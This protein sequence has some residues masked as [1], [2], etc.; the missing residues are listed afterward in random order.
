MEKP[1]QNVRALYLRDFNLLLEAFNLWLCI[2]CCK[3]KRCKVRLHGC[4]STELSREARF[5]DRFIK[6]MRVRVPLW[7]QIG[8]I[9]QWIGHLATNQ[10]MSVR[11]WLGSQK[12]GKP[13]GVLASLGKRLGRV[14]LT[15]TRALCLPLNFWHT[16]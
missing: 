9:V 7:I 8:S 4:R 16:F 15:G 13:T 6:S 1:P 2:N 14:K 3:S 11:L 12:E 10:E 5:Q